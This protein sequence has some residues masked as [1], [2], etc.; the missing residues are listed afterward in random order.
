M[1]KSE[2]LLYGLDSTGSPKWGMFRPCTYRHTTAIDITIHTNVSPRLPL[3]AL[4][5]TMYFDPPA[6]RWEKFP[7]GFIKSIV[8]STALC[9]FGLPAHSLDIYRW[10]DDVGK[11]HMADV[12]PEKYRTTAKLVSYRRDNVSD[13]ERQNAEA[14]AASNKRP[15]VPEQ[16]NAT[17][18]PTIV[19]APRPVQMGQQLTCTQKWDEYYRSQECFAPY[20]IRQGSGGSLLRPE[21]YQYCQEIKTPA[22][23]CEYDKRQSQ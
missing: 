12:V 4:R 15:L 21:A 19:N 11:I 10:V 18:Q 7:D 14:R 8:I 13:A 9:S 22:M 20:M 17:T 16:V 2:R 5:S 23:E 6:N 3:H 1:R